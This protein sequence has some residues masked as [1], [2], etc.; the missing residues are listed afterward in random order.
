MTTR[1]CSLLA[2]LVIAVSLFCGLVLSCNTASA[3]YSIVDLGTLG[4][5][6]SVAFA[7]NDA[8][9][10]V[11]ET[12]GFSPSVPEPSTWAMMLI[13]F[14]TLAFVGYRRQKKITALEVRA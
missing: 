2:R 1:I 14:A 7:I 5:S 11:G 9:Q 4:G 6:N 13:G 10:A 8:G 3:L 12:P